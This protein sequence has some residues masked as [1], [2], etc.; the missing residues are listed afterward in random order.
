MGGN[1]ATQT[2]AVTIRGLALGEMTG[3]IRVMLNQ[4]LV[5]IGIGVINGLICALAVAIFYGDLSLGVVLALAMVINMMIAGIA[6]S[7]IPVVLKKMRID[8]AVASSVFVTMCTDVAGFFSFLGLAA[9]LLR[10]LR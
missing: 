3:T 4:I 7:M 5:G 6:G 1:A 9:V 10:A 8:P 2:L